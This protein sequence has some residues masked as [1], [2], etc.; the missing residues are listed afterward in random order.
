MFLNKCETRKGGGCSTRVLQKPLL[1]REV[2]VSLPTK[3]WGYDL[4]KYV[5]SFTWRPPSVFFVL[6][7]VFACFLCLCVRSFVFCLVFFWFFCIG[8][9]CRHA[10]VLDVSL[11]CIN[12]SLVSVLHF[13]Y[14]FFLNDPLWFVPQPVA[15]VVGSTW[16]NF[17]SE[18]EKIADPVERL[19]S[20]W[21]LFLATYMPLHD[22]CAMSRPRPL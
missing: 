11:Q 7:F 17:K 19:L 1:T 12:V 22:T 5:R 20:C 15:A 3:V 21:G 9:L 14:M 8:D 2:T 18:W 6:F 13:T 4:R 16:R 10:K